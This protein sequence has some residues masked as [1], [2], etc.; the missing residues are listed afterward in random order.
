MKEYEEIIHLP[1][2]TSAVH[3]RMPMAERAAQFSAFRALTGYGAAVAETE[4][5]TER[6]MELDEYERERLDRILREILEGEP[7]RVRIRYFQPD[8]RK[9]GGRYCSAEGY[10]RRLDACAGVLILQDRRK[11]PLDAVCEIE[12]C[13]AEGQE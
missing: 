11:I 10:I 5:L 1:H 7:Q 4:R 3:P 13:G 8:A 6:K 9:A 12:I 2:P